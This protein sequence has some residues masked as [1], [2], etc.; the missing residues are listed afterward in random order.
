MNFELPNWNFIVFKQNNI[1][2]NTLVSNRKALNNVFIFILS[3]RLCTKKVKHL[4]V[5]SGL[6]NT[7]ICIFCEYNIEILLHIINI[8]YVKFYI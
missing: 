2:I 4:V 3:K 5:D 1:A 6:E 7:F 8:S